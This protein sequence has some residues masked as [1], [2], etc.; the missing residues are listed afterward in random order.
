MKLRKILM[1]T[2]LCTLLTASACG[3]QADIRGT[4]SGSKESTETSSDAGASISSDASETP[5]PSET[6][7]ESGD[8]S[9]PSG[10]DETQQSEASLSLGHNANNI[11]E[12]T[13]LGIGCKLEKDW[14]F[15]TDEEIKKIN[16]LTADAAGE[17]YKKALEQATAITDMTASHGTDSVSITFE[18]LALMNYTISEEQY[19]EIAQQYVGAPLT[20]MGMENVTV[21]QETTMFLGEEHS[22]ITISASYNG[23]ACHEVLVPIKCP[24]YMATIA[25]CTWND[26]LTSDLLEYFYKLEN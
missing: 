2:C 5:V 22:C 8:A 4:Y 19:V 7:S 23:H 20:N 21:T 13:F 10:T 6:A 16:Q 18:K 1:L 11:Y 14:T 24:G 25:V 26:N 17:D 12:N 9:A 15:L 3:K